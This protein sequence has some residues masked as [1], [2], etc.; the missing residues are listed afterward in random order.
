MGT[1]NSISFSLGGAA[2][3]TPAGKINFGLKAAPKATPVSAVFGADDSDEEQEQPATDQGAAKRQRVEPAGPCFGFSGVSACVY[4]EH[5]GQSSTK[6]RE[7]SPATKLYPQ[8]PGHNV[9]MQP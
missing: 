1:P 3:R 6:D 8:T 5:R 4:Q 9:A 2:K 7:T